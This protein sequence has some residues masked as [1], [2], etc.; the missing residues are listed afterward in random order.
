MQFIEDGIDIPLSLIHAHEAGEVIFFCGAG[1]SSNSGLPVFSKLVGNIRKKFK[2]DLNREDKDIEKESLEVQLEVLERRIA[3]GKKQIR[4]TVFDL[5]NFKN[6]K[7]NL[8]THT[9]LINLSQ[10]KKQKNTYF[11]LVTTNFDRLFEKAINLSEFK[12]KTHQPPYLPIPNIHWDGLVYLHGLLPENRDNTNEFQQLVLTSSDFG[13]AYLLEGWARRFLLELFR[14]YTICFVGYSLND[15]VVRYLSDAMAADRGQGQQNF[16]TPYAFTPE[17]EVKQWEIKGVI[18]ISYDKKN[19][20]EALHKTL[21]AWSKAYQSG[22]TA[23]E[24]V[25]S[26]YAG[27]EPPLNAE[28]SGYV[29]KLIWALSDPSGKTAELFSKLEPPASFKWFDVLRSKT[30]SLEDLSIF[31][32]NSNRIEGESL[33][34]IIERPLK[35]EDATNECI[36]ASSGYL[37]VKDN[38][39]FYLGKWLTKNFLNNAEFLSK[40][41]NAVNIPNWFKDQIRYE[42]EWADTTESALTPFMKALWLYLLK[43]K[44]WEEASFPIN[45]KVFK[46]NKLTKSDYITLSE[47][48][49][50]KISVSYQKLFQPSLEDSVEVRQKLQ[51]YIRIHVQCSDMIALRKQLNDYLKIYPSDSLHLLNIFQSKLLEALQMQKVFSDFDTVLHKVPSMSPSQLN[52]KSGVGGWERLTELLRDSWLVLLKNDIDTAKFICQS[53]K[54]Y[55]FIT[56]QRLYLFA[57]TQT[58]VPNSQWLTFLYENDFKNLWDPRL[59]REIS[60]LFLSRGSSLSDKQSL[61]LQNNI[62]N[63]EKREKDHPEFNIILFLEQLKNGKA[64]LIDQA[65][66]FLSSHSTVGGGYFEHRSSDKVCDKA[67]PISD[68]PFTQEDL[69]KWLINRETDVMRNDNWIEFCVKYPKD[70]LEIFENLSCTDQFPKKSFQNLLITFSRNTRELITYFSK[71]VQ[72]ALNINAESFQEISSSISYCIVKALEISDS[73]NNKEEILQLLDRIWELP[74]G[75]EVKISNLT[76]QPSAE[77]TKALLRLLYLD[78]ENSS[79]I[80]PYLRRLESLCDKKNQNCKTTVAVLAQ[81]S[82]ELFNLIPVW[83][84]KHVLNQFDWDA[85]PNLALIAWFNYLASMNFTP[86]TTRLLKPQVL[87]TVRNFHQLGACRAN[88]TFFLYLSF[89]EWH[90]LQNRQKSKI[91]EIIAEFSSEDKIK[92][93]DEISGVLKYVLSH[94]PL[95]H[96]SNCWKEN[97]RPFFDFIWSHNTEIESRVISIN[98]SYLCI[99][100]GEGNLK[101]SWEKLRTWIHPVK[102]Y[103]E[104]SEFIN[105]EADSIVNQSTVSTIS[106]IYSALTDEKT[107]QDDETKNLFQKLNGI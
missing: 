89:T 79:I 78:K 67:F 101:N 60:Q 84:T 103:I 86:E 82:S 29:K 85:D 102:S 18:P 21:V 17:S 4:Q 37:G 44:N 22:I 8:S 30:L 92:F 23:K 100:S 63:Y 81:N 40:A 71:I 72:I 83:T 59:K 58:G 45:T 104:F 97:I 96:R 74:V 61:K 26:N 95:E 93:Y 43:G 19:S 53:W 15:T 64:K 51:L 32:I 52:D 68:S 106:E 70:C 6:K 35:Y 90:I 88:L 94:T 66:D 77:A 55:P 27:S 41:Y 12:V 98:L 20:H 13:R 11:R 62:L 99:L 73:F 87:K 33:Y 56:F 39:F 75:G 69:K 34:S 105:Q 107:Y 7:I 42:V 3:D 49:T 10:F 28:N 16:K 80:V 31:G 54:S 47:A 5:L 57:C 24:R 91:R 76:V 48:L 65:N 38:V 50:P 1:I 14:N 36:L 46:S 9:A 2:Q 25:I